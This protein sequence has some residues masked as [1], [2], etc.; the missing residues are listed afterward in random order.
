[1]LSIRKAATEL[2]RLDELKAAAVSCYAHALDATEQY[3][4]EVDSAQMAQFR[5]S[6][7][8]LQNQWEKATTA[9]QFESVQKEF[10]QELSG[11]KKIAD[12]Q[13][14]KLR[15][16]VEAAAAAVEA[17]AGNVAAN[18]ADYEVELKR[19]MQKLN[20]VAATDD[21][22]AIRTVIRSASMN[23]A[24][25]FEQM[26]STNQ[27][28]IAQMKDEIRL[29]HQQI[30]AERRPRPVERTI[31]VQNNLEI[32]GRVGELLRQGLAFPVLVVVVR[33]LSGLETIHPPSLIEIALN[34]LL[35][36]FRNLL[37]SRTNIGRWGKQRFVAILDAA[38]VSAIGMAREIA[39][40]LSKA[41][42][43]QEHG[44]SHT[45]T[46]QVRAGV[47][48]HRAEGDPARFYAKLDQLAEAL[49]SS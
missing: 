45:I 35:M 4:I 20:T 16:D 38:P 10:Q 1:L 29:L 13:I 3:A 17:F 15:K 49:A 34:S 32:E 31:A 43:L 19:D 25:A 44:L 21:L 8:A 2:D 39:E 7:Q 41:Y 22:N 6:L 14:R 27:L 5:A 12:D 23:I 42:L 36:R 37:G 11:Y 26:R 33:N 9:S 46:L 28:A 48:D 47:V 24:A 30:Q 18:G 40:Q